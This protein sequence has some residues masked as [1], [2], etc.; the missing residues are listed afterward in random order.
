[1]ISAARRSSVARPT[2]PL[3]TPGRRRA[4]VLL[5]LTSVLLL[6]LD[7]RGN[8]IFDAVR[9]G[10]NRRWSRSSRPPTWSPRRSST[11]GAGSPTRRRSAR[12][13]TACATRSTPSAPTRSPPRPPSRTSR[14]CS[15][16]ATCRSLGDYERITAMVVGTTPDQPRP[17]HPDQQG[18]PTTASRSAWPS[19]PPAASSA[20]SR[21]RCCPTGPT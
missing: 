12:R 18:E 21:R 10:F 16:S 4:I 6:T 2:M 8:A 17:G 9:S 3:Y 19:S 13:T 11:P 7:L 1:M 5:L 14:S 15:P 20:R